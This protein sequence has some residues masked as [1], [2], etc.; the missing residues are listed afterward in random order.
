MFL[1]VAGRVTVDVLPALVDVGADIIAIRS[2]ACVG[3][4]RQE[5]IDAS[6]VANFRE[7]MRVAG[8]KRDT[9]SVRTSMERCE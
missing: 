7:A 4:N 6:L 3:G 9:V 1:A 5:S 8:M 2:A